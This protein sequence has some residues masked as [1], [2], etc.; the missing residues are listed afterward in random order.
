MGTIVGWIVEV[1]ETHDVLS[2]GQY[3]FRRGRGCESATIQ[4]IN[5]LEDAEE[6]STEIHGSS[7]DIKRAF[8]TIRKPILQMS[9]ER[10]GVPKNIE[11]Y[12][13]DL[14]KECLTI[15]LTPHAMK[16]LSQHGIQAFGQAP[17]NNKCASGFFPQ[18]GTSQGDTPS[19]TNWN[20][21]LDVLLRALH[22]I[23]P[24]PFL[25][26]TDNHLS[27]QEDTAYADDLF[28]ISA[29]REGLQLKADVVS[30]F[31]I[32]FGLR[33]A[34]HKLRSF[35]KCWGEEP[36]NNN[37]TD[38]DLLVYDTGWTLTQIPVNYVADDLVYDSVFKYLGVYIDVNNRFKRQH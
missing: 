21:S 19:P 28:S 6:S 25:V 18:T 15:P 5:A 24:T 4:V 23:D 9:W 31:T 16:I 1:W 13:I 3:G 14:D 32:I 20:A 17:S 33:I 12:I 35:A 34:I 2:P 38:Y 26:R 22:A 29:R 30:A 7:W 8:D 36:S 27:H 11:K 37:K 10:L